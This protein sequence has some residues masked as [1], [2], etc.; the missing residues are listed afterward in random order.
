MVKPCIYK[1]S[2]FPEALSHLTYI[3]MPPWA[4]LST[5][6]GRLDLSGGGVGVVGRHRLRPGAYFRR[7][8][9]EGSGATAADGAVP[10]GLARPETRKKDRSHVRPHSESNLID[11]CVEVSERCV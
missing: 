7:P 8:D 5:S 11:I 2:G 4:Q 3:D 9:S 10:P 1:Y 6:W